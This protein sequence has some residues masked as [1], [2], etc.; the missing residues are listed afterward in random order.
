MLFW[1][2]IVVSV[3]GL[4]FLAGLYSASRENLIY[5][6]VR[7][8]Y[9]DVKLVFQDVPNLTKSRPIHHLK[10]ARYPGQGITLDKT[11]PNDNSLVLLTGFF[12]NDNGIRLIKRDGSI[13]AEW[14]LRITEQLRD[15]KHC[16]NPP[17][18][19]W[20]AIPHGPLIEPDGSVIFSYES[21]GMV[22]LDRCGKIEWV[23]DELVTHHSPNFTEDGGIVVSGGEFVTNENRNIPWPFK[24]AYW[25][26]L[27]FKFSA[28]GKLVKSRRLTELFL[29]NDFA[30]ILTATGKFDT[31]IGG[32][33]HLNEVEE[34]GADMADEFIGFEAGDL[35]ISVR[36]RNLVMVVDSEMSQIKWWRIGPWI[37]QHDPDF[38]VGGK[39][40]VFNNNTDYPSE[41]DDRCNS[42]I[43]EIDPHTDQTR[44]LYGDRAGQKMYTSE[45][46]TH[47]MQ[48]GGGILITES[49]SGRVFEVD[50][51]GKVIWEFINRYDEDNVTWMHDAEIYPNSYFTL[52]DWQCN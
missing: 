4:V 13:V 44:V 15:T 5:R 51:D 26:D 21:C 24:N 17:S 2:T 10:P 11:D 23:Q 25:E 31:R 14:R 40:T 43:V 36:N 42:Q 46:G 48:P 9:V 38:Q 3:L 1:T 6:F 8:T 29:E 30:P 16:L 45:R 34:L 41:S 19:D 32:E 12:D 37:R 47:Q 33:F 49:H 7:K 27:I 35:L 39:I 50:K 18:T 52:D 20:N 22:K 28:D